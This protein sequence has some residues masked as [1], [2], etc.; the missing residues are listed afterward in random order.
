MLRIHSWQGWY[1]SFDKVV[2]GTFKLYGL[3][4]FAGAM[5][6][7]C[8]TVPS[9]MPDNIISK[10]MDVYRSIFIFIVSYTFHVS[11]CINLL[12]FVVW[13]CTIIR[14]STTLMAN[15]PLTSSFK[16]WLL[17]IV[18]I[19]L[20]KRKR[21][22]R[23]K[24]TDIKLTLNQLMTIKDILMHSIYIYRSSPSRTISTWL[25]T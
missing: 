14:L 13:W 21:S 7:W 6:V 19:L 9:L 24:I 23:Y 25:M 16:I 5:L 4:G 1:V 18:V 8:I 11:V 3:I 10:I 20:E 15:L 12:T 17:L 22:I 2:P